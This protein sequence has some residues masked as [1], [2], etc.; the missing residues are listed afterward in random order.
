MRTGAFDFAGET[1]LLHLHTVP[2]T[3]GE[4]EEFRDFRNRLRA[5]PALV[6][7]YVAAKKAILDKGVH[8]SVDYTKSKGDF[9]SALG[10]KG[11]EGL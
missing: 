8:D 9:I 5:D 6:A 3:S 10:Y 7:A 2:V 1:F 11:A 4:L